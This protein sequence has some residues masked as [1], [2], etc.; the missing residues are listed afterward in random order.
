MGYTKRIIICFASYVA[1]VATTGWIMCTIRSGLRTLFFTVHSTSR[2]MTKIV[3]V[4]HVMC[5][6]VMIFFFIQ[7]GFSMSPCTSSSTARSD[8]HDYP[9][10]W[11]LYDHPLVSR[12]QNVQGFQYYMEAISGQ[13][14]GTCWISPETI[15]FLWSRGARKN[16]KT[17]PRTKRSEWKSGA[18]WSPEEQR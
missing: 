10:R 5:F 3:G 12:F 2:V 1:V 16:E 17:T 11:D 6:R 7:L 14:Y 18:L 13:M 15:Y 8:V 4:A 9:R